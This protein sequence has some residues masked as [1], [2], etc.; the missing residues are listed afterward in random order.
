MTVPPPPPQD[1]GDL[2]PRESPYTV[3]A[4]RARAPSGFL[5]RRHRGHALLLD[6]AGREVC[7]F[8]Y[9]LHIKRDFR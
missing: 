4:I 5:M 7:S 6:G 1:L 3:H 8:E 9:S 2:P